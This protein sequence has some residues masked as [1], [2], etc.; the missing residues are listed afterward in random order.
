MVNDDRFLLVVAGVTVLD[1][2][3]PSIMVCPVS[4]SPSSGYLCLSLWSFPADFPP[5][6]CRISGGNSWHICTSS[7]LSLKTSFCQHLPAVWQL[8]V[9]MISYYISARFHLLPS[10]Q[11]VF[12]SSFTMATTH[13]QNS[14]ELQVVNF[15]F[16]SAGS[17]SIRSIHRLNSTLWVQTER[18]ILFQ[19]DLLSI[20]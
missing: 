16:F 10:A 7:S 13:H 2:D 17:W 18:T 20:N 19:V 8:L 4:L 5:Q 6:A 15:D 9:L 12:S 1:S 14:N 3:Q 11:T